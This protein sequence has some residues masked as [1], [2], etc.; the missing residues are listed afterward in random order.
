MNP[1]AP[2]TSPRP[3]G[4]G[5]TADGKVI[6]TVQ[7]LLGKRG[8]AKTTIYAHARNSG[9]LGFSTPADSL[10]LDDP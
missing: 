3:A 9:P 10:H 2:V 5:T 6:R 7:K 8:L 1:P 4:H